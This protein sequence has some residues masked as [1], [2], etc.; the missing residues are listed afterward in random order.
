MDSG[1]I[2]LLVMLGVLPV[3]YLLWRAEERQWRK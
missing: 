2:G 3:L 1:T